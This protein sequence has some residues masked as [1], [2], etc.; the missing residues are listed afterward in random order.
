MTS[1]LEHRLTVYAPLALLC[2]LASVWLGAAVAIWSFVQVL[3]VIE[4]TYW[5]GMP[6]SV[7]ASSAE[8][9]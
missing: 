4:L 7:D 5:L 2:A 9:Q 8:H 6:A 1:T 3:A